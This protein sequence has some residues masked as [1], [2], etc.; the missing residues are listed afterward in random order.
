MCSVNNVRYIYSMVFPINI[1]PLYKIQRRL[2]W[3]TINF[4]DKI[5]NCRILVKMKCVV[6]IEI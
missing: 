4:V 6:K 3:G 2:E 5:S 1:M